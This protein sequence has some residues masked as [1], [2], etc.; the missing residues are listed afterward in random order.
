MTANSICISQRCHIIV[1]AITVF[2]FSCL[3][4]PNMSAPCDIAHLIEC[5]MMFYFAK[6]LSVFRIITE[7]RTDLFLLLCRFPIF[8]HHVFNVVGFRENKERLL[9]SAL[10]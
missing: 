4:H 10:K 8:L 3:N 2:F 6:R 7:P 1:L 5:V 9:L